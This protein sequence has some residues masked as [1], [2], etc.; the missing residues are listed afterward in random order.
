M[1]QKGIKKGLSKSS[2]D[3]AAEKIKF[4][5]YN[6]LIFI[7]L[8]LFIDIVPREIIIDTSLQQ[9]LYIDIVNLAATFYIFKNF[10]K[11]RSHAQ[12]FFTNTIPI[13]YAGF[14]FFA[15]LSMFGSYSPLEGLVDLANYVSN[16]WILANLFMLLYAARHNM[17]AVAMLV[18]I[19]L[20]YQVSSE[21]FRFY[22]ELGKGPLNELI[23]SLK[24]NTGNKNIFAATV[25]I[26]LAFAIYS[27][28]RARGF[29]K[30]FAYLT[31]FISILMLFFLSARAAYISM[32]GIVL[33]IAFGNSWLYWKE[34][35]QRKR[36]LLE[37]AALI[38][39]FALGFALSNITLTKYQLLENQGELANNSFLENRLASITDESNTSNSIRVAMWKEALKAWTKKPLLG[40]GVGNYRIYSEGITKQHYRNNVYFRYPHNDFVQVL[41][42][43]GLFA[44]LTYLGLFIAALYFSLLTLF[45]KEYPIERKFVSLILLAA[46][47]GFF[48]DS[49]FN[50]PLPRANM[51]ILFTLILA[52]VILNYLGGRKS[53]GK[54]VE[55]S[56]PQKQVSGYIYAA[57]GLVG[58]F[59][60]YISYLSYSSGKAQILIDADMQKQ[61]YVKPNPKYSYAQVD[62][63]LNQ[64]LPL[65]GARGGEPISIK[66]A[67][68]LYYENRDAEALNLIEQA[69]KEMPY[70]VHDERLKTLIYIRKNQLDSAYKYSKIAHKHMPYSILDYKFRAQLAGSFGQIEDLKEAFTSYDSYD[71]SQEAYE[72]YIKQLAAN[73][74]DFNQDS[75][76][77][78]EGLKR[79]PDSKLMGIVKKYYDHLALK[80]D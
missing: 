28:L 20:F 76:P 59:A 26:K 77:L 43:S 45:K 1:A 24:W 71:Q 68:Y 36:A 64:P 65:V 73:K 27:S 12:R 2:P 46:G 75:L 49:F 6:Y 40:Y 41:F 18:T 35:A 55:A 42:E 11:Y 13:L 31:V 66:K 7:A 39:L 33:L 74:Y 56:G 22:Q 38:L 37:S 48:I 15:V 8:Y 10:A 23:F 69:A 9:R 17:K 19:T 51:N 53:L 30:V 57:I 67:K 3:S 29:F 32:T 4:A 70:S 78:K 44:L 5:D 61:N 16:F 50:F 62:A 79:Y 52:L 47:F 14:I 60:M 72:L 63:M 25:V 21:L 58:L 80:K 34:Q 54:E